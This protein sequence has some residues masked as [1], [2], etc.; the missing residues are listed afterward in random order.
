MSLGFQLVPIETYHRGRGVLVV[1]VFVGEP[2]SV[3]LDYVPVT[4]QTLLYLSVKL[5]LLPL[6]LRY[7][8]LLFV[9]P[10]LAGLAQWLV[11]RD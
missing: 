8:Y 3:L 2:L 5:A 1:Q 11:S 10:T 6:P 9:V 7:E 4:L